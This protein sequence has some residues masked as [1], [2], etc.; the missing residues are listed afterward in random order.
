MYQ[1]FRANVWKE[2]NIQG[3]LN[4][5]KFTQELNYGNHTFCLHI[6]PP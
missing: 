2:V 3:F 6:W 5:W 1:M 4:V